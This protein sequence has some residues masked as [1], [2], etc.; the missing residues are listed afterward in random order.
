MSLPLCH[1]PK[2]W[3]GHG[4]HCPKTPHSII[5]EKP[6]KAPSDG[7]SPPEAEYV[8]DPAPPLEEAKERAF[9]SPRL[10]VSRLLMRCTCRKRG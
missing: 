10:P 4:E 3:R 1:V 6:A 5:M 2:R 7:W 8:C 9:T